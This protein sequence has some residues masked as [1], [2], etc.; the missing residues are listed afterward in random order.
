MTQKR[1]SVVER[2]AASETMRVVIVTMDSHLAS[3]AARAN[4]TLARAMP[5]LELV[6]HAAAEWG[7]DTAALQRCEADIARADIV[8]ATTEH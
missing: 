6:V 4:R 8:I 3:A 7:G 2:N 5:G 1:I